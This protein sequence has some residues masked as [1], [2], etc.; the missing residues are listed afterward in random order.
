VL[1]DGNRGPR[2]DRP[3]TCI[4][5]G[6]GI[7]L[8]IGAASIIAKHTRDQIMIAHAATWPQYDWQTNKG[9]P[10]PKHLKALKE[11]GP[12]PLHRRSFARVAQA[13]LDWGLAEAAE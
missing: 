8:S 3:T 9:Y 6:D 11:H 1:V 7:S 2:W 10:A 13:E 4:V 12:C 5:G